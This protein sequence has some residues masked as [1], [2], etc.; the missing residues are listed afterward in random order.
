[1]K[2][3]LNINGTNDRTKNFEFDMMV[4]T[5]LRE[6][7]DNLVQDNAATGTRHPLVNADGESYG[8]WMF[9]DSKKFS[10]FWLSGE[11]QVIDA[12][13]GMKFEDAFTAAGYGGGAARALDFYSTGDDDSY[14][15]NKDT[16]SWDK[17]E[18]II[19]TK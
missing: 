18:P 10:L 16:R 19:K 6:L 7:A 9:D 2:F 14:V 12:E 13:P 4:A 1:M 3:I 5:V 8:F 15:F 11:R 17:K